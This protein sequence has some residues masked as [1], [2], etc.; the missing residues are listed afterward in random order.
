MKRF[1]AE[2]RRRL[3]ASHVSSSLSEQLREW[4]GHPLTRADGIHLT[5]V[6]GFSPRT[7]SA[8]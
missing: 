3:A 8:D 2:I 7:D 6:L 1:N 5:V 4:A